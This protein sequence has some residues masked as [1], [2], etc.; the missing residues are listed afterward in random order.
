MKININHQEHEV[1]DGATLAD[2]L[3]ALGL[4][5]PG[6]AVAI[7]NKVVSKAD[8]ASTVLTDGTEIVVIKAVCGG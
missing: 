3:A 2:V 6:F 4:D 8:R 1:A 5:G 7:G